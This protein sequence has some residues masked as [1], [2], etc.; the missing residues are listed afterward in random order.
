LVRSLK[1][2][3]QVLKDW[4][5]LHPSRNFEVLAQHEYD[6]SYTVAMMNSNNKTSERTPFSAILNTLSATVLSFHTFGSF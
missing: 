6:S 3:H 4:D 5:K 1:M 2:L